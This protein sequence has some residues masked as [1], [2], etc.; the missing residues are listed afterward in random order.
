VLNV[1]LAVAV[2][3]LAAGL[4]YE[5]YRRRQ[6]LRILRSLLA[7]ESAD[8]IIASRRLDATAAGVLGRLQSHAI[9]LEASITD[10]ATALSYLT[11]RLAAK[12]CINA[13]DSPERTTDVI[14]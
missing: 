13:D 1:V 6:D 8:R 3:M 9:G 5:R 2:A 7:K 12:G 11:W 4:A 10:V 14:N